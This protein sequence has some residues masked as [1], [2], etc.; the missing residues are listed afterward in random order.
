[1]ILLLLNVNDSTNAVCHL[2]TSLDCRWTYIRDR[3]GAENIFV[4][5]ETTNLQ[6]HTTYQMGSASAFFIRGLM[7]AADAR[8]GL[9]V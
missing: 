8:T 5:W 2:T 7:L 3:S 4:I 9:S 1:M 6:A